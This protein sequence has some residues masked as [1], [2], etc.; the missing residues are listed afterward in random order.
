MVKYF[1]ISILCLISLAS[2]G[3]YDPPASDSN[4]ADHQIWDTL[5]KK[6]VSKEGWVNYKDW[7]KDRKTLKTYLQILSDNPPHESSWTQEEKLAYW[8]NAY[9][10]F[11]IELILDNYPLK[12]IT[13]LHPT[14]YVPGINTIWHKKFFKIGGIETSLDEIEHKILRTKFEEPRIHF[15]IVCASFSCPKLRNEAYMASKLEEQLDEQAVDFINDL[16]RNLV[17]ENELELSKIFKWFKGDFTKKTS[18]I[19]FL[20]PY[21][22]VEINADA[23]IKYLPYNWDLNSM[24]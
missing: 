11:T 19:N 15:A 5:L 10:A 1:Y 9:N 20:Q 8:I 17:S 23:R 22:S 6:Y 21:T 7:Q 14:F 3:S 4:A 24:D 13:D 2:C 12:S 18:L 16:K